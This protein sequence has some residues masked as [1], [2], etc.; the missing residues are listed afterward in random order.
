MTGG[1]DV[2]LGRR[3]QVN[4]RKKIDGRVK[5]HMIAIAC[6]EVPEGRERWT[7]QLIAVELVR[8][9]HCRQHLGHSGHENT[10]KNKLKPWQKKE[11]CIPKPGVEFVARMEDV[12]DLY[13]RPYNPLCPVIFLDETNQQL[14]E[15]RSIPAK[16]G[17]PEWEDYEYRRCG[18]VDL[19]VAF[20]PLVCK[21]MIKLTKT[22]TA[23]NFP[24]S[25]V[26]W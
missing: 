1:S 24:I 9:G 23:V 3:E 16:S 21:R 18:V 11:W 6:L 25:C 4:R 22:R 26:N 5:A 20:E 19:F 12:L 13:H 15:K 8:L 7:L 17:Q 14:I 10:E 2:A